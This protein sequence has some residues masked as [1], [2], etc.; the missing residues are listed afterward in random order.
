M[1]MSEEGCY[2]TSVELDVIM[3]PDS[4]ISAKEALLQQL[5]ALVN[6]QLSFFK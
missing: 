2:R 3:L 1:I 4:N 5:D 6:G